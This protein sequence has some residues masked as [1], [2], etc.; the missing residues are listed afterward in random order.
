MLSLIYAPNNI[1]QKTAKPVEKIDDKV[2]QNIDEMFA[3]LGKEDGIGLGANMVG[4]LDR[5]IVLDWPQGNIKLPM[6]NPE[7][8][9]LSDETQ[10]FEEASLSYPGIK[11]KITRPK[12]IKVTYLDCDNKKQEME[13]EGYLST[14]IQHEIDYL[15][16]KVFLDHLSNLKRNI[17][18][19]KMNKFNKN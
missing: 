7:I 12:K 14:L 18:L 6:I 11:A 5:I 15:N 1:F 13:A 19:K 8:T 4:L 17:L 3:V 16:G 10:Q 9:Y 2:R